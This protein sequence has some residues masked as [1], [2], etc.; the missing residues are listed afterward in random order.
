MAAKLQHFAVREGV[1]LGGRQRRSPTPSRR[2]GCIPAR[3]P[4]RRG[5]EVVERAAFVGLE[6][7]E[8]DV[9]QALETGRSL[10][11]LP[12]LT[13]G[14]MRRGPVWNSSGSSSTI[15]VLIEVEGTGSRRAARSVY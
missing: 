14:N 2:P 13:S 7:R 1:A 11:D 6:V 3:R 15:E 12:R 9:A 5:E 4:W 10:A 8:G